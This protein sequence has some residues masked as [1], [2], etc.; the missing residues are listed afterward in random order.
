MTK[1]LHIS[2]GSVKKIIKHSG[3]NYI[4]HA[5]ILPEVGENSYTLL[6]Q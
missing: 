6:P 2:Q 4:K 5:I 1:I 3:E